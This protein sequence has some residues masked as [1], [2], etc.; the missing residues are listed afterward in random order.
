MCA[1]VLKQL[2]SVVSTFAGLWLCAPTAAAKA[3]SSSSDTV[4][5]R[6]ASPR[7]G[8][9]RFSATI[10]L[11]DAQTV[12]QLDSL[13]TPFELRLPAQDIDA[14]FQAADFG[15]LSGTLVFKGTEVSGTS[16]FDPIRLY[17]TPGGRF[18]FGPKESERRTI[19]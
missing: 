17:F 16:Y 14:R 6:V 9:V 2:T 19:P 4:V 13:V 10:T 1:A 7:Q 15:P 8:P 11:K 18:G 5:L 3:Q 12:R